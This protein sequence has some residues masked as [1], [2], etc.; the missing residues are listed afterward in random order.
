LLPKEARTPAQAGNL[1]FLNA[2]KLKRKAK[3]LYIERENLEEKINFFKMMQNAINSA[4]DESEVNILMPTQKHSKKT[5]TKL[6]P[7]ESFFIEG[8]KI[9][10][11]KSEKGNIMLLKEA[12]K[13]DIWMHIKDIP[14]SHV[15]IRTDKQSIPDTVLN[16]AAKLCVDFSVSGA[17]T[18]L[19]DY[20]QRSNVKMN[21]GA[22]VNYVEYKTLH[23][24]V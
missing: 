19:V 13:R 18:Y 21:E 15:I 9:M 16:F 4:K 10:L 3:S 24:E 12:K 23:V 2:K 6:V 17:G 22:N 11:G 1:L 14:S 20:T 7:Y 5:K 8:F